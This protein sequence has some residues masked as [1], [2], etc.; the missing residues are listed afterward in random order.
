MT[1]IAH[2]REA[3][4]VSVPGSGFVRLWV[5]TGVANN[6]DRVARTAA[7]LLPAFSLTTPHNRLSRSASESG[8]RT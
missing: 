4:A 3:S 2:A 7:P 8:S 6:D 5:A 1:E